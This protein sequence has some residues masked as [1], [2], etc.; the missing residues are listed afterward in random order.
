MDTKNNRIGKSYSGSE[1]QH[2]D[3]KVLPDNILIKNLRKA[4]DIYKDYVDKDILIVY[5]EGKNRPFHTY[6]FHA[7]IENFQH[8]AGVKSPQGAVWFFN[9][10]SKNSLISL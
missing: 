2:I 7:G 4:A 6:E 5:A 8:L 1:I 10:C 9:K 3:K